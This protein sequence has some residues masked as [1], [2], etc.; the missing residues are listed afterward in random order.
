MSARRFIV[1]MAFSLWV[2]D[3]PRREAAQIHGIGESVIGG[4]SSAVGGKSRPV[5]TKRRAGALKMRR[6][7]SRVKEGTDLASTSTIVV[8]ALIYAGTVVLYVG[9]RHG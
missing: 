6:R 1:C 2:N 9:T 7:E 3:T 4:P 5:G 8:V